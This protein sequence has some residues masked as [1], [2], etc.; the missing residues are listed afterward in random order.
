[1]HHEWLQQ[2]I[3]ATHTN[4]RSVMTKQKSY[5]PPK[6]S[7]LFSEHGCYH[8]V[9]KGSNQVLG[10]FKVTKL[11]RWRNTWERYSYGSCSEWSLV[12]IEHFFFP[13]NYV[14]LGFKHFFCYSMNYA[15]DFL[16]SLPGCQCEVI[17]SLSKHHQ[18]G[19]NQSYC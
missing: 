18:I 2:K 8:S 5:K 12:L 17:R 3:I 11:C 13:V 16:Q 10:V 9:A 15:N 14:L 19:C 1:M 7:Q 6:L 4:G